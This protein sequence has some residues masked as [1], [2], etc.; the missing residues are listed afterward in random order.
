MINYP[1][2]ADTWDEKEYEAIDRVIKSNRF[3]MGPE[4]EKFEEEFAKYFG[5]KYA[6]MVNSGSSAK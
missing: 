4:V 5:S 2:A 3:T 1:L 6:V